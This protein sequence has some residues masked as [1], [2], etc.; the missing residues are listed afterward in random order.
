MTPLNADAARR[1]QPLG[2]IVIRCALLIPISLRRAA[3]RSPLLDVAG[4]DSMGRTSLG[5]AIYDRAVPFGAILQRTR[6][7]APQA[8]GSC[9]A[10]APVGCPLA[11]RARVDCHSRQQFRGP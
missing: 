11:A 3:Q 5:P 7:G 10:D 4:R 1:S 9:A 8:D 2:S 6:A